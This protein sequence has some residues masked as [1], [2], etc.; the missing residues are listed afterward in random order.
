MIN[1]IVVCYVSTCSSNKSLGHWN[2]LGFATRPASPE[3]ELWTMNFLPR[4]R[5]FTLHKQEIRAKFHMETSPGIII[6]FRTVVTHFVRVSTGQKSVTVHRGNMQGVS[7][8]SHITS[9]HSATLKEIWKYTS[10]IKP[11]LRVSAFWSPVHLE[12]TGIIFIA[13]IKLIWIP[14]GLRWWKSNFCSSSKQNH[15]PHHLGNFSV[16]NNWIC[17]QQCW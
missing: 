9:Y 17:Q 13:T 8:E 1:D 2:V 7:D 10:E 11:L 3:A 5:Q 15:L 4:M 14:H 6:I 12:T 16:W